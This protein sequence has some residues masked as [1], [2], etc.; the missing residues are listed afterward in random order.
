LKAKSVV[1]FSLLALLLIGSLLTGCAGKDNRI[2]GQDYVAVEPIPDENSQN[3][4][5]ENGNLD[6]GEIENNED[7]PETLKGT[8]DTDKANSTGKQNY[9]EENG[10]VCT[11]DKAFSSDAAV[12]FVNSDKTAITDNVIF[13]FS[14]T[15]CVLNVGDCSVSEGTNGSADTKVVING[16]IETTVEENAESDGNAE[17]DFAVNYMNFYLADKYTGQILLGKSNIDSAQN[18][19]ETSFSV[20][21]R[22]FKLNISDSIQWQ[23]IEATEWAEPSEDEGYTTQMK[24]PFVRTIIIN[25]PKEYNG[26]VLVLPKGGTTTQAMNETDNT[27][28]AVLDAEYD[29]HKVGKDDLAFVDICSLAK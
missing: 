1:S 25:A 24:W 10:I 17:F 11:A 21:G 8:I 13:A 14:G 29:G 6:S 15:K 16:Y 23:E 2:S 19:T 20:D 27:G 26:A 3:E 5:T 18:N 9:F 4:N 12:F 22:N 28:K 7:E